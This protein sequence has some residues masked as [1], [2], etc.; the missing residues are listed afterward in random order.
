MNNFFYIW[1]VNFYFKGY[2]GY[3]VLKNVENEME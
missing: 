3:N 1:F 2:R